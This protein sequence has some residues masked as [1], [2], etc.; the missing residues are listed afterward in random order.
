MVVAEKYHASITTV[1][2]HDAEG[3]KVK[4][5]GLINGTMHAGEVGVATS[6]DLDANAYTVKYVG[7]P[8]YSFQASA[9]L[10]FCSF[11]LWCMAGLMF[12]II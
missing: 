6:F 9:S 3:V 12:F 11:M 4:L 5:R 7:P 2:S 1:P 10:A 8:F